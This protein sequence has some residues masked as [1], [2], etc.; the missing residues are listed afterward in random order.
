MGGYFLGDVMQ[1]IFEN[2]TLFKISNLRLGA[3]GLIL[4]GYLSGKK[5]DPETPI[6]N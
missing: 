5:K 1:D 4:S 3:G 2:L 6:K